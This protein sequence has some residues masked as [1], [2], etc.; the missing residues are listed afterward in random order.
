M[1]W[2][3]IRKIRSFFFLLWCRYLSAT[4]DLAPIL[5]LLFTFGFAYYDSAVSRFNHYTTRTP[6][7][8]FWGGMLIYF[9]D[10]TPRSILTWNDNTCY[11]CNYGR[12]NSYCYTRILICQ[13][14]VFKSTR[15]PPDIKRKKKLVNWCDMKLIDQLILCHLFFI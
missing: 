6:P 9:L 1:G 2:K 14:L 7:G 11:S 8:F 5:F 15:N 10:I 4:G 13:L 3:V 12:I